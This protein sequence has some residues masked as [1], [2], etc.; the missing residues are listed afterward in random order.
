VGVDES[1]GGYRFESEGEGDDQADTQQEK[2]ELGDLNSCNTSFFDLDDE[3]ELRE[4]DNPNP[5][6]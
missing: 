3:G 6:R 5:N 2:K 4:F 1:W